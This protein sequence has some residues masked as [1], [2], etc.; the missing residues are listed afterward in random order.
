VDNLVVVV[1]NNPVRYL[2]ER[3]RARVFTLCNQSFVWRGEKFVAGCSR[4]CVNNLIQALFD[5]D[6]LPYTHTILKI[7]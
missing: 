5:D 3:E 1:Y 2:V 7:H 4:M 6:A